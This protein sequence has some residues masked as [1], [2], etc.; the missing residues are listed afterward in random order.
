MLQNELVH[1][2]NEVSEEYIFQQYGVPSCICSCPIKADKCNGSQDKGVFFHRSF[3]MS[4]QGK[5]SLKPLKVK[6]SYST[7]HRKHTRPV[8]YGLTVNVKKT[9]IHGCEGGKR[10]ERVESFGELIGDVILH[11]VWEEQDTAPSQWHLNGCLPQRSIDRIRNDNQALQFRPPRTTD[12]TACDIFFWR[13]VKDAIYVLPLPINFNHLRNRITATQRRIRYLKRQ[14]Y[15]TTDA[16]RARERVGPAARRKPP[17]GMQRALQN[18]SKGRQVHILHIPRVR[19]SSRTDPSDSSA[20][21]RPGKKTE[22]RNGRNRKGVSDRERGRG[23]RG[24][25]KARREEEVRSLS[26]CHENSEMMDRSPSVLTTQ[27]SRCGDGGAFDR[28]ISHEAPS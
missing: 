5:S 13:F 23:G 1:Q 2:M 9:K 6:L 7:F 11:R 20:A 26:Q 12:L 8:E 15:T 27:V 17:D 25:G 28:R 22:E 14:W 21:M 10:L 19:R 24:E 18:E 4:T 3:S 16:N